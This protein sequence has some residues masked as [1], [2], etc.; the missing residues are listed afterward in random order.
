[1]N[2][3]EVFADPQIAS[4]EMV[5]SIAHPGHGS[6]KMTGFPM[7]FSE[8]PCTV[9]YPAPELGAH[10]DSVLGALGYNA[11]DIAMLHAEAQ[12]SA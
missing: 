2:L 7:K 9:R 12:A 1:M 11:T 5:L 10:T 8:A 3:A 4:Q 6:V